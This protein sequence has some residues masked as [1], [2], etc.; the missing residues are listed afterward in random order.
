MTSFLASRSARLYNA[1]DRSARPFEADYPDG[2][3][4]DDAGRLTQDIE[5][6]PI[7]DGSRVVG[8]R[9]VGGKDEALSPKEFDAIATE[10]TGGPAEKVAIP[11]NDMGRVAVHPVTR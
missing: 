7:Q 6:R 4:T 5:G 2:V 8:R 3:Q 11:G 9:M 1:P 10:A